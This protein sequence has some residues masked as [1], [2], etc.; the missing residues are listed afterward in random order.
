[1]GE[2]RLYILPELCFVDIDSLTLKCEY[3]LQEFI[4]PGNVD[5]LNNV[6][7]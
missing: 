5:L 7:C 3:L 6:L 4:A 2:G 1:M